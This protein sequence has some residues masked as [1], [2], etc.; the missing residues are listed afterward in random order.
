ML[1]ICLLLV[2][3]AVA[4][5]EESSDILWN[6]SAQSK[7][8][9][10][11]ELNKLGKAIQPWQIKQMTWPTAEEINAA[12]VNV[13]NGLKLSC[14]KWLEKFL[15]KDYLPTGLDE[16][17]VA[18]KN[19]GLIR[20]E[21]EQKD[22]CDVF[23]SRFKK[24]PYII[25]VQESPSNVVIAVAD[26]RLAQ[27]ARTDHKKLVVETA[28][29]ILKEVFKPDPNSEDF[30]VSESMQDNHKISK[31]IWLVKSVKRTDSKG[32]TSGNPIIAQKIGASVI[33][34]RTDGKVV[35]FDIVKRIKGKRPPY[36][37]VKRFSPSLDKPDS[38]NQQKPT[39]KRPDYGGK[40][41]S[42]GRR[43]PKK[44]PDPNEYYTGSPS[45]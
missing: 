9:N 3:C 25:H 13:S 16:H 6:S 5:P 17:L 11:E 1:A 43:P 33:R 10:K 41:S 40:N 2:N 39:S 45:D 27:K 14:K 24:G 7:I 42:S 22:L 38:N 30:H 23:I 19:W 31:V 8:L 18:M 28:C 34:S 44:K 36:P 21:S 37:Y 12:S 20:K 15:K 29:L 26:E 4:W 35:V 32:R